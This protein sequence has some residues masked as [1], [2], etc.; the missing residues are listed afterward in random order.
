MSKIK[1]DETVSL[2]IH[3][4]GE[5]VGILNSCQTARK[6]SQNWGG[7]EQFC[8]RILRAIEEGRTEFTFT[9]GKDA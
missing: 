2:T 5:I 9:K 4:T 7:Q 3:L 8:D 6:L 1:K